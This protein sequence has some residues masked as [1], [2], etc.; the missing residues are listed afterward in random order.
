MVDNSS[1]QQV[2]DNPQASD[3]P[4]TPSA[5][6]GQKPDTNWPKESIPSDVSGPNL[7]NDQNA[8]PSAQPA[9]QIENK[10]EM[11]TET[12]TTPE[13]PKEETQP[14]V[15]A[16]EV[17][18]VEEANQTLPI[19]P[20]L[21]NS[22]S[23]A[24]P[25]AQTE[26][27]KTPTPQE[28]DF[29]KL[30]NQEP[31]EAKP[32]QAET[33]SQAEEK[34]IESKEPENISQSQ[35]TTT[36]PIQEETMPANLANQPQ[37]QPQT[38]EAQAEKQ[39]E[40]QTAQQNDM[41]NLPDN[42]ASQVQSETP[43]AAS[44]IESEQTLPESAEIKPDPLERPQEAPN[45]LSDS[46]ESGQKGFGDLLSTGNSP[47]SNPPIPPNPSIPLNSSTPRPFSFGDLLKEAQNQ[48]KSN[49]PDDLFEIKDTPQET[50]SQSSPP[51]SQ[52][53]QQPPTPPQQ[54]PT[55]QSTQLDQ[56]VQEPKVIEKVVE[57]IVEKP[58]EVIKEFKVP[59]E[60]EIK[61]R[62]SE[63]ILT[64]QQNRR[65]LANQARSRRK[66][67][68]LDKIMELAKNTNKI[69]NDD[70]QR[71]LHVS[72]STATNYLSELTKSGMLKREGIRGGAKYSI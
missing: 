18:Q 28:T 35:E 30:A 40:N 27:P 20:K 36:E 25:S 34:P 38:S 33:P 62:V 46:Q 65:T 14:Q 64:E 59:D 55:S 52:Q 43:K 6:I 2:Q 37:E 69:S 4:T 58:V 53:N 44:S 11:P 42:Q 31:E 5:S 13:P 54:Q 15:T 8:T 68:H 60:E 24:S 21:A 12:Q 72:Q 57:K 26:E 19:S 47:P 70:I 71:L 45:V 50:D 66:S 49:I 7:A 29:T 67:K 3:T 48:D 16:P 1:Q 51:P 17:G 22:D 63:H 9:Q 32:V 56:L 23:S 41:V 61:K 39:L 10:E